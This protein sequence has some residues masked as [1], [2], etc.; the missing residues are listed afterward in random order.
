MSTIQNQNYSANFE[1]SQIN[2]KKTLVMSIEIN[3]YMLFIFNFCDKDGAYKFTITYY[4]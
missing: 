1:A 2:T 3:T 4:K